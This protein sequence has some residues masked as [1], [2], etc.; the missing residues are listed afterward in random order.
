MSAD[1]TDGVSQRLRNPSTSDSRPL[2]H[3]ARRCAPLTRCKARRSANSASISWA[4]AYGSSCSQTRLT[5]Q[6]ASVRAEVAL[7][8][9]R[10]L[11]ASSGP[12]YARLLAGVVPVHRTRVPEA[13]VNEHSDERWPKHDVCP[14][15]HP[16]RRDE[17]ALAKAKTE[18]M[19]RRTKCQLRAGVAAPVGATDLRCGR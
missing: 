11:A 4:A 17:D 9:R 3:H 12:Q 14:W 19:Q 10:T 2:T 7:A 6:P 1:H 15:P 18:A 8:S 5:A 13:P 16:F